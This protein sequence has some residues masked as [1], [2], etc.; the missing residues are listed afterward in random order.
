MSADTWPEGVTARYLTIGGA[1]VDIETEDAD[2][3]QR[4]YVPRCHGCNATSA[5]DLDKPDANAW[6]QTHAE[7]CRALPKPGGAA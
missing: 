1:T 5:R 3:T 4:Q 7:T 2:P 6:A